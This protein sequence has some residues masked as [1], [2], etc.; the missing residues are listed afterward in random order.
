MRRVIGLF[1]IFWI[2]ISTSV[3]EE[4]TIVT[5]HYPPFNYEER[6]EVKGIA[7]KV[8]QAVLHHVDVKASIRVLPWA[9]AYYMAQHQK[10]VLIYSLAR[11]P[12]RETLFKWVG[13]IAPLTT[14]VYKLKRRTDIIVE[15]FD[16]LRAYRIGVLNQA[17]DHQYLLAQG[18]DQLD[19]V[20]RHELNVKKLQAERID[21]F[22]TQ[23][24]WFVSLVKSLGLEQEDFERVYYLEDLS[25]EFYMA[26][27]LT[28]SDAIV[29]SFRKALRTIKENGTYEAILKRYLGDG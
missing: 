1:I 20:S 11:F 10:N 16:D 5:E 2:S 26:F 15:T 22:V 3:A 7:T 27:S 8:V 25:G 12:E 13:A 29:E 23:E 18:F 4:I 6:G 21:L 14:Y 24:L 19:P 9:R 17:A 28:T